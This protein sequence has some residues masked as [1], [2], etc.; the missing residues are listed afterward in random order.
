MVWCSSRLIP[1]GLNYV[2]VLYHITCYNTST[3]IVYITFNCLTI[4]TH[5]WIVMSSKLIFISL[6]KYYGLVFP[7][8]THYLIWEYHSFCHLMFWACIIQQGFFVLSRP[9]KS[10]YLIFGIFEKS[11]AWKPVSGSFRQKKA[12]SRMNEWMNERISYHCWYFELWLFNTN[13][14][15]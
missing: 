6:L 10:I 12:Q 4:N 13:L 2:N 8:L 15:I 14:L 1:N 3:C 9:M 11:G 7:E 5:S